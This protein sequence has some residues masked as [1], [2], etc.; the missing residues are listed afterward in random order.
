MTIV[1]IQIVMITMAATNEFHHI[2]IHADLLCIDLAFSFFHGPSWQNATRA[3]PD[4]D[5]DFSLQSVFG[6]GLRL[7]VRKKSDVGD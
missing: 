4:P 5:P 7:V 3:D 6:Q 1:I 2:Q